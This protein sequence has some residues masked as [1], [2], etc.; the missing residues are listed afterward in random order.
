MLSRKIVPR[1]EEEA[2]AQALSYR[3]LL[4]HAFLMLLQLFL[5]VVY[6]QNLVLGRKSE[7][8][9]SEE[10]PNTSRLENIC[11][12]NGAPGVVLSSGARGKVGKTFFC[13]THAIHHVGSLD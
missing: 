5:S 3:L 13:L 6:R 4:D 2:G 8:G 9:V 7:H 12:N 1:Q 10:M 11:A